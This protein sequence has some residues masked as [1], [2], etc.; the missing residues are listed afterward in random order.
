MPIC[1]HM[2]AASHGPLSP[3]LAL[4][5]PELREHALAA[6]PDPEW[7]AT[8]AQVRAR[9]KVASARL[10]QRRRRPLRLGI[11]EAAMVALNLLFVGAVALLTLTLTLI[12]DASR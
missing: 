10:P 7:V 1:E 11:R 4:V 2:P 6:L 12:A 8:V 9:S 5:S 3:E